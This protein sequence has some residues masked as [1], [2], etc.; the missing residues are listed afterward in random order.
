M[1]WVVTSHAIRIRTQIG[2]SKGCSSC[3]RTNLVD[4]TS[5]CS[6]A[7]GRPF[8][9]QAALLSDICFYGPGL[10]WSQLIAVQR[11]VEDLN[12]SR[13]SMST[14]VRCRLYCTAQRIR[15]NVDF[16]KD[17]ILSNTVS[18]YFAVRKACTTTT[19]LNSGLISGRGYR[20]MV[21]LGI[22]S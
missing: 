21:A 13:D 2:R 3:R 6:R 20:S 19:I 14:M 10:A 17:L 22:T 18:R 4:A 11:R 15:T 5:G 16:I 7:T 9:S 1:N 12:G 8:D